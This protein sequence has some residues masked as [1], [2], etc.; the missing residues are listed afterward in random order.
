MVKRVC[1]GC[2]VGLQGKNPNRPGYVP[3]SKME[4]CRRCFFIKHYNKVLDIEEPFDNYKIIEKVNKKGYFTIFL[5]DFLNIY[6]EIINLYKSIN[7]KKILI[8]TKSD[9]IPKNIIYSK[10]LDNIKKVYNIDSE[11]ILTSA[12]K[13]NNVNY[14]RKLI[15]EEK[16]V[17]LAGFT[18][19]G[20]SSLINTV[21]NSDLTVSKNKNT[22]LDIIKI[23]TEFGNIYDT[24]G[25]MSNHF[26]DGLT[27]NKKINPITYQLKS[28]YSL[29]FNDLEL[30]CAIDN[31]LTFYLNN[32]IK[33]TKRNIQSERFAT[34][35]FVPENSDLI[36]KGLGFIN[37]KK[38]CI[39]KINIEDKVIEVR[40][41]IVGGNNEQNKSNE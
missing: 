36:I 2:G 10:L 11:I 15:E 20:K 7:N 39:I 5:I 16:N 41:T 17:F 23:E 3:S 1:P 35:I 26:L 30:C 12:N 34:E 14:L 4:L 22:T 6:D 25:F 33:I 24:P 13:K 37:I 18:N 40:P 38:E 9:I 8:L 31:S 32:E 21:T 19:T 29:N 28:K 27:P